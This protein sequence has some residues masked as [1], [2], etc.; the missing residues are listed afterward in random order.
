[1]GHIL[2]GTSKAE[3]QMKLLGCTRDHYLQH[4][5]AQFTEGMSWG[6][7]GEWHQDH[8]QPISSFDHKDPE[9]QKICWHYTNF[10]PLWAKDNCS[11]HDRI[12]SE[13]QVNLL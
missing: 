4:M 11:K 9:Q 13:H 1:M 3:S 6:N 12:V 2:E 10:Q 7:Y 5:E 8:I